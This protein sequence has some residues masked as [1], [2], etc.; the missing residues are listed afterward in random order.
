MHR[1]ALAPTTLLL[2]WTGAALAA[3]PAPMDKPVRGVVAS[4]PEGSSILYE[5]EPRD[6]HLDCAMTQT[7][8][9]RKYTDADLEKQLKEARAQ[10]RPGILPAAECQSAP[11]TLDILTG[12]VTPPN[13]QGLATLAPV[14]KSD[15]IAEL[16]ALVQACRKNTVEAY[17][18]YVRATQGKA[19]RSCLVATRNYRSSF[20]R[21]PDPKAKALAWVADGGETGSCGSVDMSRFE[22]N[23][24]PKDAGWYFIAHKIVT[25][26][27]AELVPGVACKELDTTGHLYAPRPEVRALQCDY[28]EFPGN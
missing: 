6:D 23:P 4:G 27:D 25:R 14:E 8:V 16:K 28:V 10:F 20:H 9:L 5:C 7:T 2:A 17:V 1:K 12:K 15:A 3:G 22:Y 11:G 19:A 24:G 26:P 21:D 13:P 18:D